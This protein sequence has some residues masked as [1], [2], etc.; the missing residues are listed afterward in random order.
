MAN[1]LDAE[2]LSKQIQSQRRKAW[3]LDKDIEKGER[4]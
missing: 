2:S 1:L 3:D 4:K